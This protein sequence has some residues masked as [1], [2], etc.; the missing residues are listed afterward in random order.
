MF[1]R[2]SLPSPPADEGPLWPPCH[3]IV[4]RHDRNGLARNH[5]EQQK[6]SQLRDT[7]ASRTTEVRRIA[8]KATRT[9]ETGCNIRDSF[10]KTNASLARAGFGATSP[11]QGVRSMS[12]GPDFR[13]ADRERCVSYFTLLWWSKNTLS[14]MAGR[15]KRPVRCS[16]KLRQSSS[17]VATSR[18]GHRWPRLNLEVPYRRWEWALRRAH[19]ELSCR[20]NKGDV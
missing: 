9:G 19:R 12:P 20:A 2:S 15:R 7:T 10:P 14:A 13:G 17:A 6:E 1:R 3:A 4:L 8:E 11:P 18:A 5:R 16:R